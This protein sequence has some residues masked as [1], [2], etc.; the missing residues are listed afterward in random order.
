[1]NLEKKDIVMLAK[2]VANANKKAPVAYRFEDQEYSYSALNETL[3]EQFKAL[4]GD[5]NSYRRNKNDIFEIMQEVI[6]EVLPKKINEA[7][8]QFAEVRQYGQ[9]NKPQ[10]VKR[11]G[12]NRAKQFVTK[13][14]LAGIYEVF[15]LDKSFYEIETTAYGGAAQI[16]LEEFLDGIVDFTTLIDIMVEGLNDAVYVEIA[17]AL[18]GLVSAVPGANSVVG[19]FD[20]ASFDGLLTISRAYGTPVIYTSLEFAN[21][22]LLPASGWVSDTARDLMYNQGFLGLY[23]GVRVVVLPQTFTDETNAT[24]VLDT[25]FAYIIPTNENE[26]PVKIALEGETIIDEYTNKDRSREIQAYRKFGVGIVANNDICVYE[27]E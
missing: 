26:M 22:N 9:G 23:K 1:M 18:T 27:V 12:R 11:A 3:R 13:V 8:G 24:A 15:K 4:A 14:G 2:Q 7:Y 10:F 21:T 5:Y 17:Q 20:V 25:N 19:A 6:D 16:G